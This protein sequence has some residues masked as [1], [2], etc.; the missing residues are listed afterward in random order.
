M[1]KKLILIG[2]GVFSLSLAC[3]EG[4]G[5]PTYIQYNMS[6][7]EKRSAIKSII[8]TANETKSQKVYIYYHDS[9]SQ[10]IANKV[11]SKIQDKLP[12]GCSVVVLDQSTG[13]PKYPSSITPE[14]ITVFVQN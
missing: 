8:E 2:V 4:L 7:F 12:D 5:S 6:L 14:G 10:E 3:A 11:S 1:L 9:K 13:Q